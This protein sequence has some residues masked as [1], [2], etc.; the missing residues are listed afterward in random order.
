LPIANIPVVPLSEEES[1]SLNAGGNED[2]FQVNT[3]KK[4]HV[5]NQQEL[6]NLT[7]DLHF[8]KSNA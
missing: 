2:F 3:S 5:C 6:D 1:V 4:P 8:T 7:K